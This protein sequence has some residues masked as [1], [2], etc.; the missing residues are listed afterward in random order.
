MRSLIKIFIGLLLLPTLLMA[1]NITLPENV[2]VKPGGFVLSGKASVM[3]HSGSAVIIA[4]GADFQPIVLKSDRVL[5]SNSGEIDFEY[6][7]LFSDQ[8]ATYLLWSSGSVSLKLI[9]SGSSTN[10][11]LLLNVGPQ[12][13]T[14]DCILRPSAWYHLN[15]LWNEGRLALSLDE[16]KLIDISLNTMPIGDSVTFGG[17]EQQTPEGLL[18]KLT[19][20]CPLSRQALSA[21]QIFPL[22]SGAAVAAKIYCNDLNSINFD[23]CSP[24]CPAK[25]IVR[26]VMTVKAG[27]KFLIDSTAQPPFEITA[28]KN[29]EFEFELPAALHCRIL[30]YPVTI[31]NLLLNGSFEK[32][33]DAGVPSDWQSEITFDKAPERKFNFTP[34]L[35]ETPQLPQVTDSDSVVSDLKMYR[36][37]SSALRVDKYQRRSVITIIQDGI[38]VTSGGKYLWSGYYHI[39]KMQWGTGFFAEIEIQ[40]DGEKVASFTENYPTPAF[41]CAPGEWRFFQKVFDVPKLET[42]KLTAVAKVVID[43]APGQIY[44]DDFDLR[45]FPLAA[46]QLPKEPGRTHK[47]PVL[48]PSEL[49]EHLSKLSPAVPLISMN[50]QYVDLKLNSR[51]VPF[52]GTALLHGNAGHRIMAEAGI[53]LQWTVFDAADHNRL[54]GIWN[55]D[56]CYDFSKI[57]ERLREILSFDPNARIGL[58]ILIDPYLNFGQIHPEAVWLD[59]DGKPLTVPQ[60]RQEMYPE[61]K[62]KNYYRI[63]YI[64]ESFQKEASAMMEALGKHLAKSSLGK[65]V[66]AIHP[67]GGYDGQW[68]NWPLHFDFCLDRSSGTLDILRNKIRDQ[69]KDDIVA[70]RL[71]W[72]NPEITFDTIT[73]PQPFVWQKPG[74]LRDPANPVHRQLIDLDSAYTNAVVESIGKLAIA[75][76]KGLGRPVLKSMYYYGTNQAALLNS[77]DFDGLVSVPPYGEHRALGR[78]SRLNQPPGS[79]R[80]HGKY[81]FSELDHRTE[82]SVFPSRG[83][84]GYDCRRYGTVSGAEAY[85]NQMRKE[86][87]AVLTSG[88]SAWFYALGGD[89][90]FSGPFLPVI[91]EAVNAVKARQLPQISN[92]WGE[93]AVFSDE[94]AQS[95]MSTWLGTAFHTQALIK[96]QEPLYQSGIAW[97]HYLI[98]DLEHPKRP[99]AKLNIF[100]LASTLTETQI[101]WIEENLQKNGAVNVFIF[102]AGRMASGGFEKNIRRLAGIT[103]KSNPDV[104]VLSRVSEARFS[105]RLSKSLGTENHSLSSRFYQPLFYVDDP[106]AVP[107]ALFDGTQLLAGAVKRHTDWTA[108]YLAVPGGLVFSPDFVRELAREAGIKPIGPAGDTTYSGS[109]YLVLHAHTPGIKTLSWTGKADLFDLTSGQIVACNTETFSMPMQFGETRWFCRLIPNSK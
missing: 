89:S 74:G 66:F 45:P 96:I 2:P 47:K 95:F 73:I 39:A 23:F 24:K 20:R 103:V 38:S 71:A 12:K 9:V 8:P 5:N 104:M 93:T 57:D 94:K 64:A 60:P 67:C 25:V 78:S 29:G 91:K 53:N 28:V 99:P 87:G 40:A 77:P 19:L 58:Y 4:R 102:D 15:L 54:P 63:S 107:L 22:E 35:S 100:A 36:S 33:T 56:G 52:I 37:G 1:Q 30:V 81:F 92:D 86:L 65:S 84:Y 51:S 80:L 14:A 16:Q 49:T 108:V 18:R 109:G 46:L 68:F 31:G 79:A 43:G 11:K 98:S 69:Y 21:V 42:K 17:P 106:A 50:G 6:F 27:D 101:R 26:P 7:P 13:I 90:S 82:Y 105:D 61:R 76:Q 97:Q 32:N 59:G 85:A 72:G 55:A 75:F 83:S 48:S 10:D 41:Y 88:Q 44:F 3:P 34:S 62:G 70:L